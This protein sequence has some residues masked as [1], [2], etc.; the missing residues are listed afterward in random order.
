MKRLT[1]FVR[2]SPARLVVFIGALLMGA[3]WTGDCWS[4]SAVNEQ[5]SLEDLGAALLEPV[6]ASD[7]LSSDLPLLHSP[8]EITGAGSQKNGGRLTQV[9]ADMAQ[10][11]SLLARPHALRR[12]TVSQAR[13][14]AGLD[15]LIAD[16]GEKKSQYSGGQCKKPLPLD[17]G[18]ASSGTGQEGEIPGAAS[19]STTGPT[20]RFSKSLGH[21]AEL[22]KDLWGHLPERQ[23]EQI[24]QPLSAEFLP[25]YAAEIEAYFRK[26]AEPE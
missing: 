13:A 17:A 2:T 6:A 19:P 24:L 8:N 4:D 21:A 16:L 20:D 15:L 25:Q 14:V 5:P 3:M 26:L 23:R 9:V 18:I 22:I 7:R 1:F 10:A 11:G 12:A